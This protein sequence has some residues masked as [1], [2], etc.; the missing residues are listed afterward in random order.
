MFDKFGEF[1]SVEEL[2]EAAAGQ[3]AQGDTEALKELAAENGIDEEDVLDYIKGETPELA[4]VSMAAYGRL[5][6]EEKNAKTNKG[7]EMVARV[8]FQAARGLCLRPSFSVAVMRK[9][10]RLMEVYEIMRGIA[11]KHKSGSVGVACGTDKELNNI[12]MAYYMQGKDEAEK[13]MES[14]YR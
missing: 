7:E 3:L 13:V 1:D 10:K 2:N 8:L 6:V 5:A 4:S 11:R 14:M 12:I 9:G